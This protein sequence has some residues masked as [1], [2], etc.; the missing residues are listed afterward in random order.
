MHG[1]P[2]TPGPPGRDGRDGRD[3][4]KG[5]QG[6]AGNAGPQGLPGVIG[7]AGATGKDGAKGELGAQGP[8]GQKGERGEPGNPG[9][10]RFKNWKECAWKNVNDDRDNGLIKVCVMIIYGDGVYGMLVSLEYL[11][12]SPLP[13]R[14]KNLFCEKICI[15]GKLSL[16]IF[17]VITYILKLSFTVYRSRSNKSSKIDKLKKIN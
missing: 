5:D 15:N 14:K 6:I 13:F 16:V 4:A 3:G 8:H 10:M 1:K 11:P 17:K 7:P 2:G 12:P 9:M